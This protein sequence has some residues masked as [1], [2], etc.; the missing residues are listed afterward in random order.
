MTRGRN[1]D[2]HERLHTARPA[3]SV[4]GSGKTRREEGFICQ[5]GNK[6]REQTFLGEERGKNNFGYPLG[7]KR[8]RAEDQMALISSWEGRVAAVVLVLSALHVM[9]LRFFDFA[10]LAALSN[11]CYFL[12]WAKRAICIVFI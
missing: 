11:V 4:G 3:R 5:T 6:R 2:V 1:P 12:Y 8:R 7:S 9:R 10:A